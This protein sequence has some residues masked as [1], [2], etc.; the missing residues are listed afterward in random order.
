MSSMLLGGEVGGPASRRRVTTRVVDVVVVFAL[1]CLLAF[2]VDGV[3]SLFCSFSS[4]LGR[5]VGFGQ[6]G[7]FS[8]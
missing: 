8:I 1:F 4:L 2:F 3:C 6:W 5:S 7:S